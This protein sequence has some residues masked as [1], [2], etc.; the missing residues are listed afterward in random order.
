MILI[1][2]IN[3]NYIGVGL[4]YIS[5]LLDNNIIIWSPIT[6]SNMCSVKNNLNVFLF[7]AQ[8]LRVRGKFLAHPLERELSVS[9]GSFFFKQRWRH[10][11]KL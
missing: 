3:T 7:G 9:T 11:R 1:Y 10:K 8:Y 5:S 6:I 4:L 2:Y